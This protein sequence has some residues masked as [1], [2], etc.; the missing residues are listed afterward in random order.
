MPILTILLVI[1]IVGVILYLVNRYLPMEPVI[2]NILYLVIVIIL[3]IWLL[4][5]SGL[6]GSLNNV[7]L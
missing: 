2:K 6:L 1:I 5:V 7:R 4:R 3:I